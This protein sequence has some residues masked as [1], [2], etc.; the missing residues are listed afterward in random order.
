ME[1]KI[2]KYT[3]A[4]YFIREDKLWTASLEKLIMK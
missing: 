1:N 3:C 2:N 4:E